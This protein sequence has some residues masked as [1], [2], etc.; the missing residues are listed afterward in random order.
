MVILKPRLT[1]FLMKCIKQFTIYLWILIQLHKMDMY[2]MEITKRV[3]IMIDP[4]R[5][6]GWD[7]C[8]IHKHILQVFN[9]ITF[10]H[11]I[12]KIHDKIVYHNIF[13]STFL[14]TL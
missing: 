1:E 3:K 5:I 8:K 12:L 6:I 9:R 13:L 11:N 14:L 10:K 2:L 7:L 4:Q